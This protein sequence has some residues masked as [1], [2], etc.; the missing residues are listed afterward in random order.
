MF[1][2]SSQTF[3]QN[4]GSDPRPVLLSLKSSHEIYRGSF[5]FDSRMLNDPQVKYEVCKAWSAIGV[6]N[7]ASVF[8]RIR[9]CRVALS[10]WKR[11]SEANS[12]S[13]II[14]LQGWY[15][16]EQS[17]INPSF[18]VMNDLKVQLVKAYKD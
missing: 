9:D 3:L 13:K 4:R 2:S 1:P 16:E 15:D 12:K 11:S 10:R 8:D 6:G 7:G 17:K 14:K 18:Q 5:R